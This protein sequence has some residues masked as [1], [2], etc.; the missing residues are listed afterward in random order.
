[1]GGQHVRFFRLYRDA[2]E[3]LISLALQGL[4][5]LGAQPERPDWHRVNGSWMYGTSADVYRVMRGAEQIQAKLDEQVQ[6]LRESL[7]ESRPPVVL[8]RQPTPGHI[9]LRKERGPL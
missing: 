8:I 6:R 5:R 7:R 3:R 4:Y 1:M 9:S 2:R